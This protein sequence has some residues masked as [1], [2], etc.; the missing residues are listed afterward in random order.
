MG[1]PIVRGVD[2][3]GWI[4][5]AWVAFWGVAYCN[6]AVRARGQRVLDWFKPHQARV[7]TACRR[8]AYDRL[9]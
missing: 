4:M 6:M 9:A 7:S 1:R 2:W 5:L 3:R 8:A